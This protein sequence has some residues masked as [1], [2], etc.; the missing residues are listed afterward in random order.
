MKAFSVAI[1]VAKLL[2][3]LSELVGAV[4]AATGEASP[5]GKKVTPMEISAIV[6]NWLPRFVEKLADVVGEPA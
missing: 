4:V 2:P 3:M 1:K 6:S 5:G